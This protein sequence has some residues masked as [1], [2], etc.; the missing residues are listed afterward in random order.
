[1]SLV[2]KEFGPGGV[3][4][5][6]QWHVGEPLP[7]LEARVIHLF[8]TGHEL[9]F[10]IDAMKKALGLPVGPPIVIEGGEQGSG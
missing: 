2:F 1:M 3:R 5:V 10:L 4:I 8:A 9:D 6:T 7:A